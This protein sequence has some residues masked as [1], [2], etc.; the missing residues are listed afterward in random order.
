MGKSM[1]WLYDEVTTTILSQIEKGTLPWR[2]PWSAKGTVP[3]NP[4]SKNNYQGVNFAYLSAVVDAKAYNTPQ[5]A[6]YKQVNENGGQVRKGE[7]SSVVCFWKILKRKR[8]DDPTKTETFP[9]LRYYRVFNLDQV[10]GI[11][12]VTVEEELPEHERDTNAEM[13]I[14]NVGA[15]VHERKQDRAYYS[16][17][18]DEI[19]VPKLEQF[20]SPGSYYATLLHEHVHWTAHE[21]RL[22]R[23]LSKRFGDEAYAAEELVA[24]L[25]ATMLCAQLQLNPEI[26]GHASYIDGWHSV[27]SRDPKAIFKAST[28]AKQASEFLTDKQP[29]VKD[30]SHDRVLAA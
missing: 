20:E 26:E 27:L 22:N 25:G 28:L 9:I 14:A 12:P 15:T 2:K 6:T 8:D 21:T 11:E 4:F 17:V 13:F 16:A 3:F 10:E 29:N 7:K 1:E 23:E 30:D 19:V 24:E 18:Q 5:F